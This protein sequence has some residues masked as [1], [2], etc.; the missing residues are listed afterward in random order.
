MEEVMQKLQ[1]PFPSKDI[2][3]RVSRSGQSNGK[4]YA[5]VLAYVTNRA[6]QNRLDEVFGPAGWQNDFSDFMQ[7]VLCT[8]SC[9]VDGEWIKKSDGA[10]QTQ[11]E[12][13]KGGLSSAMKRAAVQ[14]GI[15]RYLYRLEENYVQ[16]FDNKRD[17]SNY[18]NDKK[19]NV[20]SYWM[21]PKLPDW[22]LPADEKGNCRK[23]SQEPQNK[24]EKQYQRENSQP[25]QSNKNDSVQKNI[26]KQPP[27]GTNQKNQKE[28][29]N[30]SRCLKVIGE[31][32]E[33]TGLK[34]QPKFIIPLFK[35]VTQTSTYKSLQNI[36]DKATEE[37]LRAFYGVLRPVNDL[38][39][40]TNNYKVALS[41]SL[42]Y[43]QILL[44]NVKIE[45]LFSCFI[46][47]TKDHVKEVATFIKEDLQNGNLTKIA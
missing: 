8:I 33:T 10:E 27:K 1:A 21:P 12:S 34:E 43:V 41:D 47:L 28:E 20:K 24:S 37:E 29:F 16:V 26:G 2:E 14:W 23:A 36:F 18:I 44:P 32:L 22:A 9:Y 45:S 39:L 38:V 42:R 46:H 35:K 19:T 6:I 15:G 7:G 30:R 13:L 40:I 25:K 4:K 31:Y 17:G 11:F 3:W 5:F